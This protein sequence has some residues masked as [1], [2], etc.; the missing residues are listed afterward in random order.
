MS[1]AQLG[2]ATCLAV[3]YFLSISCGPSW[4]R[5]LYSRHCLSAWRSG[6][7][8]VMRLKAIDNPF[9]K[10]YWLT[11]NLD[12]QGVLLPK[13]FHPK[14]GPC[15]RTPVHFYSMLF[16]DCLQTES[17]CTHSTNRT[18]SELGV[19][20]RD[21]G[22]RR[23]GGGVEEKLEREELH[24][25]GARWVS[26]S[27]AVAPSLGNCQTPDFG[28]NSAIFLLLYSWFAGRRGPKSA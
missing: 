12:G 21:G 15:H 2:Q 7:L 27:F 24:R 1:Q 9:G 6:F 16:K 3:A 11:L 25:R 4:A 13:I 19:E 17:I 18:G 28:G 20:A 10:I 22:R 8:F 23:F 5:A 26:H 14:K